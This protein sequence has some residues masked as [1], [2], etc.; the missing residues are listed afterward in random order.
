[1]GIDGIFVFRKPLKNERG[2]ELTE[3]NLREARL[4][5]RLTIIDVAS[6]FGVAPSTISSWETGKSRP[7]KA[8]LYC[9]YSLYGLDTGDFF[10]P[11]DN[12]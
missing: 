7:N 8:E 5:A 3:V 10:C 1:M 2:N 6:L 4:A 11:N 9:L 12:K